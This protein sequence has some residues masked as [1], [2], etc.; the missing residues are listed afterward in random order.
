LGTIGVELTITCTPALG[1]AV[2][3]AEA[4]STISASSQSQATQRGISNNAKGR[5]NGNA[6][7]Q[8][9]MTNN[10]MFFS[11]QNLPGAASEFGNPDWSG[12]ISAE[13]RKYSG[14]LD[15]WSADVVMGVDKLVADDL[16]IGGLLG[17]G[18]VDLDSATQSAEVS[19]VSVGA[20]FAKRFQDALFLDGFISVAR[21]DYTIDGASFSAKR[22]SV[23]LTLSGSYIGDKVKVTPS[24]TL[25]AYREKLPAYTGSGGAVA[26]NAIDNV[27]LNIGA[28]FEPLAEMAN[29]IL[30][31]ISL[32]ADY[33]SSSSA[34]S[35]KQ[36]FFSP[37][38]GVGFGAE[39]GTGYLSI[40]LDAGKVHED[41]R[42][43]GLRA[44]YEFTF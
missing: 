41:V 35:G 37:R 2:V 32:S 26:A 5:L 6:G 9:F 7:G 4:L 12:W 27:N 31:Y 39:L 10:A 28:K 17:Y 15:G 30:P 3:P 24:G 22:T 21:P 11:T 23:A 14:T 19:S 38:I 34:I 18:R 8:N 42:D 36:S 20:Y 40:D 33:G 44:S 43:V 13:G 25:S 29:G 1:G 16:I